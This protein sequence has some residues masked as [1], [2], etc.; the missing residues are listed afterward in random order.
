MLRRIKCDRL[1]N[2]AS[3]DVENILSFGIDILRFDCMHVTNSSYEISVPA[4]VHKSEGKASNSDSKE[5]NDHELQLSFNI[6]YLVHREHLFLLSIS[7]ESWSSIAG[8][9]LLYLDN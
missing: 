6:L 3:I 8:T 5:L 1:L 7:F 4:S 9:F 2:A